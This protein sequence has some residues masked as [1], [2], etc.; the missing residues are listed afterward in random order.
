[1]KGRWSRGG[2]GSG[3]RGGDGESP[4]VKRGCRKDAKRGREV[5]KGSRRDEKGSFG[6][7][8]DLANMNLRELRKQHGMD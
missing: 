1:M 4:G 6:G 8:R 5:E 3:R 2:G 7:E